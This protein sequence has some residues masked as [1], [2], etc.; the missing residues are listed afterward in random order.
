MFLRLLI[1]VLPLDLKHCS[2]ENAIKTEVLHMYE[3]KLNTKL[4]K[5]ED[6]KLQLRSKNI[7]LVQDIR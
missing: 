5:M 7:E 3:T 6:I 4:I 2:L 1:V